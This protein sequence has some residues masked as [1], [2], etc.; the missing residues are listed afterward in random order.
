MSDLWYFVTLDLL[1]VAAFF[2]L[3]SRAPLIEWMD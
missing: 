1:C 2:S 3:A